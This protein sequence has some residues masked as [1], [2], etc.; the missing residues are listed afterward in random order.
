MGKISRLELCGLNLAQE[1]G[2][3]ALSMEILFLGR[4]SEQNNWM[5][6][7]SI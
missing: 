2:Y 7:Y 5:V 6:N 4:A 3:G 1:E